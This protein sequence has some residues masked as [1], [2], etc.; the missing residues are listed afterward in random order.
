VGRAARALAILGLGLLTGSAALA[1]RPVR[2]SGSVAG[3]D[4]AG[5]VLV[6]EELVD[7]GRRVRHDVRIDG[8]TAVVSSSRLRPGAMRGGRAYD[9]IPVSLADV[10]VGDFVIVEW[11]EAAGATVA[12]RVT[13]VE[14]RPGDR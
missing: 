6:V 7:K 5:G 3:V 11:V 12:R 2:F 8:D 13:I 4:L 1:Q 10:L 14:I 9:E